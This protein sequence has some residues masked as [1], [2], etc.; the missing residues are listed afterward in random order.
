MLG[1][2]GGFSA[3]VW[4]VLGL[5][6][7]SYEAFKQEVTLLESF[8][9]A[10]HQIKANVVNKGKSVRTSSD[11]KGDVQNEL[12]QRTRY[13]YSYWSYLKSQLACCCCKG[14]CAS[15]LERLKLHR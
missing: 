12:Q 14:A 4:Q 2:I 3:L 10:D 7:G 1:I 9:S 15:N 11:Y 6:L 8:Y 13:V 5:C